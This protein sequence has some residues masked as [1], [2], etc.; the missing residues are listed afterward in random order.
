[1]SS[2]EPLVYANWKEW[3]E[4]TLTELDIAIM[5][6]SPDELELLGHCIN[7]TRIRSQRGAKH[8]CEMSSKNT[9]LPEAV[10]EYWVRFP[11]AGI[12]IKRP[13]YPEEVK[14]TAWDILQAVGYLWYKLER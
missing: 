6:M 3:L 5:K 2:T 11:S 13:Q 1:M 4:R 7:I 8:F 9:N 12:T 14:A 10:I